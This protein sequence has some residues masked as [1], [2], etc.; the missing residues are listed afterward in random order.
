MREESF[1]E[2]QED[3]DPHRREERPNDYYDCPDPRPR[4]RSGD[5]RGFGNFGDFGDVMHVCSGRYETANW[6]QAPTRP[7]TPAMTEP[8]HPV[9]RMPTA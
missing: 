6:T 3:L 4:L 9:Q 7:A 5:F 1:E 2:Q 8:A